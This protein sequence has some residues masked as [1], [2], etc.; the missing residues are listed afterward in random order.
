MAELRRTAKEEGTT[1]NQ[2]INLA[3]AEKLAVMRHRYWF[4]ERAARGDPDQALEVLS[5]LGRDQPPLPG[6]ELDEAS[7]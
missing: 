4:E 7:D 6:D 5:R 2:F 1:I 3:V